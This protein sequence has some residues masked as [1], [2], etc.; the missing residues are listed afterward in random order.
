MALLCTIGRRGARAQQQVDW[1]NRCNRDLVCQS[2]E[3]THDHSIKV[4]FLCADHYDGVP[5]AVDELPGMLKCI[6]FPVVSTTTPSHATAGLAHATSQTGIDLQRGHEGNSKV[7]L[8]VV[9]EPGKSQRSMHPLWKACRHGNSRSSSPSTKDWR[10]TAHSSTTSPAKHLNVR[11][12]R[13]CTAASTAT[14]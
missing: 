7:R 10:H 14:C 3:L 2:N 11:T 13:A 1:L 12:G 6:L 9:N 4:S 5:R 8:L